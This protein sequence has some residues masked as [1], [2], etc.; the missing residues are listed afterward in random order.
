M[1][2]K[3][4]YYEKPSY[5]AVLNALRNF[6][7]M[8][9]VNRDRQIAMPKIACG[10]DKLK[11]KTVQAM[12]EFIFQNSTIEVTIYDYTNRKSRVCQIEVETDGYRN[13]IEKAQESPRTRRIL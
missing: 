3:Y 7:Q 1:I 6:R 13:G 11:W 5:R 4:R 10:L 2:T 12:V 8:C 9:E